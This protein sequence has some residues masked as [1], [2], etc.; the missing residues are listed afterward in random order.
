MREE[1]KEVRGMRDDISEMREEIR[2]IKAAPVRAS[3]SK[4]TAQ[5]PPASERGYS[6]RADLW[7]F[8]C[9]HGEDMGKWDGKPTSVL[10]ALVC[11][12]RE[13]CTNQGRST[14]VKAAS[15]SHNQGASLLS[16]PALPQLLGN[17]RAQF[18]SS[19]NYTHTLGCLGFNC[20]KIYQV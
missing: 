11:K 10:A 1:M 16:V 9:D 15:T 17:T 7:F 6:P 5:C 3:Y 8:L 2:K 20:W 4:V 12:L 18:H 19:L 13:G 14:K